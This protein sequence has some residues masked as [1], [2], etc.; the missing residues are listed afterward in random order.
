[1]GIS[2]EV[3]SLEFSKAYK[4]KLKEH[5]S[6]IQKKPKPKLSQDE[7]L[8]QSWINP[9]EFTFQKILEYTIRQHGII[10]EDLVAE[11]WWDTKT[12]RKYV[13]TL[14]NEGRVWRRGR[15]YVA[16]LDDIKSQSL[17]DAAQLMSFDSWGMFELL[18]RNRKFSPKNNVDLILLNLAN[19][20]GAFVI[21]TIIEA[22]NPENAYIEYGKLREK[23]SPL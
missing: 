16:V 1:M 11:T 4:K 3:G 15:K 6:S 22:L 7:S 19:Q 23:L 5:S 21:Y 8:G 2:G 10:H 12:V 18:L 20:I 17:K 9:P 14:I 13:K